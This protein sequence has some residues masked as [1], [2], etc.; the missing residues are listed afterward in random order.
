MPQKAIFI[1]NECV[2]DIQIVREPVKVDSELTETHTTAIPSTGDNG[3][4]LEYC[5]AAA[6]N[7]HQLNI[8]A[9]AVR[10]IH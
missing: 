1:P 10:K 9:K 5:L 6:S 4:L 3:V 7:N 8:Q 2:P